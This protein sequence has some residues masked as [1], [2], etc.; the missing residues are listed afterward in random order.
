MIGQVQS[1]FT[2]ID[3]GRGGGRQPFKILDVSRFLCSTKTAFSKNF[4]AG[5]N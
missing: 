2:V 5:K 4:L 1:G 3:G